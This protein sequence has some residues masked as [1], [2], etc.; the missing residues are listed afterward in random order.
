LAMVRGPYAIRPDRLS[1]NRPTPSVP[2]R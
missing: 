1:A 2:S